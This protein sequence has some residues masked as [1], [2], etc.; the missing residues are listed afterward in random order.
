MA[1]ELQLRLHEHS[2]GVLRPLLHGQSLVLCLERRLH[3]IVKGKTAV[4]AP[5]R[6]TAASLALLG[7]GRSLLMPQPVP[8]V[9][10]TRLLVRYV[11]SAPSR[12]RSWSVLVLGAR[13]GHKATSWPH[14]FANR[15]AESPLSL[16]L[17]EI[18]VY[19]LQRVA[20]AL[21]VAKLPA[22][23]DISTAENL[24][25]VLLENQCPDDLLVGQV[26]CSASTLICSGASRC[27]DVHL[28]QHRDAIEGLAVQLAWKLHVC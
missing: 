23:D 9:L 27:V 22:L 19:S 6:L 15:A 10:G 26:G 3:P 16:R 7:R 8:T 24:G 25:D 18:S 13:L 5:P 11:R 12:H 4:A 28:L 2:A 21:V 14:C 1:C 17:D 20:A